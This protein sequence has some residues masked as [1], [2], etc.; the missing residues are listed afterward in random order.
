MEWRSQSISVPRRNGRALVEIFCA[1]PVGPS[2]QSYSLNTFIGKSLPEGDVATLYDSIGRTYSGRRQSD[3]RIAAV[4]ENAIH[5]CGPIL[6][7][8][9]GAG[10]YEPNSRLVGAV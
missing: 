4:I 5:G 10:S 9:A 3:P 7:V 8:G 1:V 6:N 2:I